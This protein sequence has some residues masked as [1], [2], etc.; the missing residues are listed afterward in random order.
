MPTHF[1]GSAE[2]KRALNAFINLARATNSLQARLSVQLEGQGLTVGQFGVLETLLHL[3]PLTQCVL[4]EKLLRSGGNIT[5]VIDNLEKHRLVRRERQTED[6]RTI[7][8]HLTPKGR[9]LIK[10]VVPGH[11]KMILKEMSQLE[12][13]EQEELRRLCRKLGTGEKSSSEKTRTEK[14]HDSSETQ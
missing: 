1:E 13:N 8:I 11:A 7:V 3:G 2:T 10:R 6:R 9:R 5:L 14:K 4:G 12:P